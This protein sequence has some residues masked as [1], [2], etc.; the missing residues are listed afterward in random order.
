MILLF[1]IGNTHTHLGLANATRVQRQTNIPTASWFDGT[2]ASLVKKFVDRA[3]VKAGFRP[4]RPSFWIDDFH[5]I[6][7]IFMLPSE[8]E[9]VINILPSSRRIK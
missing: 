9:H 5:Q 8:I 2:A 7:S 4:G 6:T 1:D 3:R